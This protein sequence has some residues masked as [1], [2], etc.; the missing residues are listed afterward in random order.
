MSDQ[1][2]YTLINWLNLVLEAWGPEYYEP[3]IAYKFT[4]REF[5]DTQEAPG[6][7]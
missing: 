7:D 1:I 3:D 6:P 4:N 5:K 2:N